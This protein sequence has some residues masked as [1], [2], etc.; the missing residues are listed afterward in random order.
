MVISIQNQL[1]KA[2]VLYVSATAAAEVKVSAVE[3]SFSGEARPRL[4]DA[5]RPHYAPTCILGTRHTIAAPQ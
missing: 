5:S 4:R 1:P 3:S 2:R